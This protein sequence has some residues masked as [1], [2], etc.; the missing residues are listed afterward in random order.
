MSIPLAWTVG[1]A[2]GYDDSGNGVTAPASGVRV[3]RRAHPV[4]RRSR[5]WRRPTA[6][7]RGIDSL[8]TD[9]D[10]RYVEPVLRSIEHALHTTR[11]SR[12]TIGMKKSPKRTWRMPAC[13]AWLRARGPR[14]ESSD[15]GSRSEAGALDHVRHRRQ[16]ADYP[17][18][19]PMRLMLR[20]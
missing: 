8:H 17:G 20:A 1:T 6:N 14:S 10:L 13:M 18:P 5:P 3:H 19:S 2:G 4:D 15:S 12:P 11:C 9:K 16:F 7:V